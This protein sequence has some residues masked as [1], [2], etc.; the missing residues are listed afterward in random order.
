MGQIRPN[1]TPVSPAEGKSAS[2]WDG[3]DPTLRDAGEVAVSR[4]SNALSDALIRVEARLFDLAARALTP[5][6][7]ESWLDAADFARAR[8][9]NLV[10][11]FGRH[12][13]RRYLRACHFKPTM[14]SGHAIDF[15]YAELRVVVHELLDD[16]LAP[17]ALTDAIQHGCWLT[18]NA[19]AERYRKRLGVERVTPNDIPPGPRA[20]EAAVADAARDQ[21]WR[22]DAKLKLVQ[23]LCKTLPDAVDGIYRDLTVLFD[24]GATVSEAGPGRPPRMRAPDDSDFL[25][26]E[27]PVPERVPPREDEVEIEVDWS[28]PSASAAYPP[29]VVPD[30]EAGPASM[31]GLPDQVLEPAA[32]PVAAMVPE[33]GPA[34][35]STATASSTVAPEEPPLLVAPASITPPPEGS[36]HGLPDPGPA[37]DPRAALAA[38]EPGCW[39]EIHEPGGRPRLLKLAWISPRRSLF[40]LTNRRGQRALSLSA[41]EMHESLNLGLANVLGSP[42]QAE[43]A[44]ATTPADRR[45]L[46]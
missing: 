39:L 42:L 3:L 10:R 20:I 18:L 32:T 11:D 9:S 38:L 17:G 29:P 33:P 46:A 25:L 28:G 45:K 43:P 24:G 21:P 37:M 15:D 35:L 19:L 31:G 30:A 7:R 12:F 6:E 26:P 16:A 13:E 34:A 23:A 1:T 2:A 40:L 4:L 44:R 22:H 14:L 8:R 5:G 41:E 27:L 36:E